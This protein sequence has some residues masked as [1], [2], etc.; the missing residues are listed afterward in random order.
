MENKPE[1]LIVMYTNW[2][3]GGEAL[4]R[5]IF[6][7]KCMKSKN[8]FIDFLIIGNPPKEFTEGL[9]SNKY[10]VSIIRTPK[11]EFSRS[12]VFYFLS[13][14]FVFYGFLVYLIL[15]FNRARCYKVIH[16]QDPRSF[17]LGFWFCKLIRAKPILHCHGFNP[18][19]K[20]LFSRLAQ[21]IFKGAQ[22]IFVSKAI[23]E[24]YISPLSTINHKIIY[25]CIDLEFWHIKRKKFDKFTFIHVGRWVDFKHQP[26]IIEI[27]T[28]LND[29]YPETQLIIATPEL[30]KNIQAPKNVFF[31]IGKSTQEI[32]ELY[33]KSHCFVMFSD[34]RE[35][36]MLTIFEAMAA[37]LPV[38]GTNVGGMTAIE[39]PFKI[40]PGDKDGLYSL[41]ELYLTDK[42]AREKAIKASMKNAKLFSAETTAKEWYA[43]YFQ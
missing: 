23:K 37:G 34:E 5:D 13:T 18:I 42:S 25:N 11:L 26:D 39:Y 32:R 22:F 3:G 20:V 21:N 28:K 29:K 9:V 7:Q 27:F 38:I 43:L 40:K 1:V 41:M 24:K 4:I 36:W 6:N 30:P 19:N 33:A 2:L 12:F 16:F 14:I 35:G 8:K 31:K 17:I 15:N 10:K